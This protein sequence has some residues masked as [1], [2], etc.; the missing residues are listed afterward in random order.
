MINLEGIIDN[1]LKFNFI[2]YGIKLKVLFYLRINNHFIYIL[3]NF[4]TVLKFG[5]MIDQNYLLKITN[6]IDLIFFYSILDNMR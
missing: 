1:F 3:L 6:S 4:L 2:I 5:W